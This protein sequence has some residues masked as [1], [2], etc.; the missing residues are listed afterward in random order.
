MLLSGTHNLGDI[1]LL[2][3]DP[4]LAARH[5]RVAMEMC[6]RLGN[7]RVEIY[8][9]AGL[10]CV[11]ALQRDTYSAGRL[12]AMAEGLETRLGT[13]MV[14]AERAQYERIMIPLQDDQAFRS[15]EESGREVD[16]GDALRELLTAS[17]AP[18]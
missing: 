11:S 3:Q 15:G 18:S 5:Y 17:P 4:E 13:P 10:A 7:E 14:G 8:C 16:L 9:V 12:W 2:S 1:A 6:R